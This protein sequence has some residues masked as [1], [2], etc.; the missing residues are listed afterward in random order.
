MTNGYV[1][2]RFYDKTIPVNNKYCV[3]PT[4]GSLDRASLKNC[5]QIVSIYIPDSVT[6]IGD[7]TF[8]GYTALTSVRLPAQVT[9]LGYRL[10]SKCSSLKNVILPINI[11]KI[12]ESMFE[13]CTS[14]ETLFIP[15]SVTKIEEYAF[16]GCKSLRILS[17]RSA[18]I[19]TRT[20]G[21]SCVLGCT[22]EEITVYER[23]SSFIY[24]YKSDSYR[25]HIK[26]IPINLCMVKLFETALLGIISLLDTTDVDDSGNIGIQL[27]CD[28]LVDDFY[29]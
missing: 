23:Y 21:T 19:N 25:R 16:N 10:F 3:I 15:D 29:L 8:Y 28:Y 18:Y 17:I 7:Y 20:F 24:Q 6:H 5:S 2:D 1:L 14:L 22:C 11:T 27:V 12:R 4:I 26:T 13:D 9:M